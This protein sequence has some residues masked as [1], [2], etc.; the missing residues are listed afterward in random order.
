MHRCFMSTVLQSRDPRHTAFLQGSLFLEVHPSHRVRLYPQYNM[1]ELS[2]DKKAPLFQDFSTYEERF[3]ENIFIF[4]SKLP[5]VCIFPFYKKKGFWMKWWVWADNWHYCTID[6]AS[7][8]KEPSDVS[9][10]KEVV[11]L[12][13]IFSLKTLLPADYNVPPIDNIVRS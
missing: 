2:I 3:S 8:W 5:V 10:S 1:N 13:L 12:I 11:L 4:I 7:P 6:A 9:N